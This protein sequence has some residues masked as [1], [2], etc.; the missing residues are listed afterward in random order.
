M[1][2]LTIPLVNLSVQ[3]EFNDE[4]LVTDSSEVAALVALQPRSPS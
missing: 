1:Q 3:T 4:E 2:T